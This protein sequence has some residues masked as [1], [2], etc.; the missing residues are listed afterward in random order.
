LERSKPI[1]SASNFWPT[2]KPL[3]TLLVAV[4][5]EIGALD[6]A[7]RAVVADLNLEAAV[8][9]FE[10]GHGDG[11]VLVDAGGACAAALGDAAALELLHAEAD[12]LLLD[13]DVE[14]HGLHR[15]ALAMQVERFLAGHAPGDVRHVDHAVDVA[16]EADEQA[17][18]GRVLD[19][20]LDLGADR[21]LVGEGR[22]R[23]WPGP[24]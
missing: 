12:P 19:L 13:V 18:L 11:L 20:A 4:A 21:M 9:H 23:D 3:R 10:H 17:E 16:V 5:A 15:L 22:P 1:T 8:A 14:N 7:G 2:W 6:E 24:A